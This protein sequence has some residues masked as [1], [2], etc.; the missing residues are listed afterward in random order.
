MG[1]IRATK[2]AGGYYKLSRLVV[3]KAYRQHQFGRVLV[4]AHKAW[5]RADARAAGLPEAVIRCH[6]QLYV[7]PFY[8][9]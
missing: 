4:E 1:T 8:A 7:R 2:H 9:R 6:S 5:I 3:L